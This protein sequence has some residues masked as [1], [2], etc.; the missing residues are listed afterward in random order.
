MA[1]STLFKILLIYTYF[2]HVCYICI[3]FLLDLQFHDDSDCLIP[4]VFPDHSIISSI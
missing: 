3:P 2:I 1:V 4:S